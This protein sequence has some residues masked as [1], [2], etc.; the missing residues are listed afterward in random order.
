M[1]GAHGGSSFL[2]FYLVFTAAIAVPALMR[3]LGHKDEHYRTVAIEVLG[4]YGPAA[5]AAIP[6]LQ[7]LS[8]SA[9]RGMRDFANEALIA[10]NGS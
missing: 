3:M 7:K 9:D 1:M 5:Q 10:I 8:K 4:R 6:A 2:L